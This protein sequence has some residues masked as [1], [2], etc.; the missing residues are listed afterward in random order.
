MEESLRTRASKESE[1]SR[2]IVILSNRI[3]ALQDERDQA[4]R[5]IHDFEEVI[6]CTKTREA[7]SIRDVEDRASVRVASAEEAREAA[8]CEIASIKDYSRK[9]EGKLEEADAKV[10]KTHRKL[11]ALAADREAQI[12]RAT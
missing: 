5:K 4:L 8:L 3:D 6:R 11:Q 10:E 7:E 9:L 1:R 12:E 2:E